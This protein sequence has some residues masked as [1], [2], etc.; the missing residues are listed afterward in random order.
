MSSDL[1]DTGTAAALA[2][3]DLARWPRQRLSLLA[4][5]IR[6]HCSLAPDGFSSP[7]PSSDAAFWL[8]TARMSLPSL[9][10]DD[11]SAA[12]LAAQLAE[13]V[14]TTMESLQVVRVRPGVYVSSD[15]GVARCPLVH[16]LLG[17]KG[18]L[19]VSPGEISG[20]LA[21][22]AVHHVASG[23][24]LRSQLAAASAFIANHLPTLVCGEASDAA[25]PAAVAVAHT[26]AV[27]AAGGQ[28]PNRPAAEAQVAARCGP[29]PIELD[30]IEE[31][32]A[33]CAAL[34]APE[35][36]PAKPLP[37]AP[38]AVDSFSL[39]QP[40]PSSAKSPRGGYA[41]PS[42]KQARARP[43]E[44]PPKARYKRAKE[45]G[46]PASEPAA[47]PKQA[48]VLY[49]EIDIFLPPRKVTSIDL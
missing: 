6:P 9:A 48:T 36:P 41:S 20:A 35:T 23:S 27:E 13:R 11:S 16:L 34:A 29:L 10:D 37:P 1:S 46:S 5:A 4:D 18:V 25:L 19:V 2:D 15:L 33:F 14:H 38:L 32:D 42:A 12:D 28:A 40:G 7:P 24:P 21:E 22:L 8:N 30:T 26:T 17:L 44:V 31:L 39:Q 47:P 49:D 43:L 3:L 45:G